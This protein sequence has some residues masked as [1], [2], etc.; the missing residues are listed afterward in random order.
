[1]E[2]CKPC[3]F[4]YTSRPGSRGREECEPIPQ[5]CPVG[6]IALAG[7]VSASQCVCLPGHGGEGSV[8]VMGSGCAECFA[9]RL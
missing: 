5:A 1:M 6:Q 4:G 7:A 2:D 8:S 9:L 3:P